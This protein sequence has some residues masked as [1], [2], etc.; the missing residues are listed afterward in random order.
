MLSPLLAKAKY[1][2]TVLLTHASCRTECKYGICGKRNCLSRNG[3]LIGF[4][5][6]LPIVDKE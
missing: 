2:Y 3:Q 5:P 6:A 4:C 1:L